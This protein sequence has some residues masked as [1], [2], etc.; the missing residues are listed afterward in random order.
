FR[1]RD[2]LAHRYSPLDQINKE[3]VSEL[4]I[5]FVRDMGYRQSFQGGPTV[6]DGV[7]YVS[8]QTGVMALDATDG[9]TLWEYSSPNEG[10]A[11]SDSAPRGG[12]L[13]YDGK[14]FINLR[15]GA[16]VA[17][18]AATG[19]ELWNVQLTDESLNEGFTTNPIWANG[20]VVVAP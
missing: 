15:H 5:A 7:M 1:A 9:T 10:E 6:W 8:T 14:V 19:D 2:T 12:P 3:N 4:Q 18:D 16:T 20:Q 11:I 17:L 13:V